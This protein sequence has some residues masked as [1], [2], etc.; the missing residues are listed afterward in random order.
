MSTLNPSGCSSGWMAEALARMLL[1]ALTM[2]S[3]N[4]LST[5]SISPDMTLSPEAA[6][7]A[8]AGGWAVVS[9][10]AAG[11]GVFTAGARRGRDGCL[12]DLG[13]VVFRR[14][15]D[16]VSF[17]GGSVGRRTLVAGLLAQLQVGQEHDGKDGQDAQGAATMKT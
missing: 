15:E 9:M 5:S 10:S 1:R 11:R 4:C 6:G 12:G 3:P 8:V 14:L 16:L 17:L 2:I 7:F 13:Q